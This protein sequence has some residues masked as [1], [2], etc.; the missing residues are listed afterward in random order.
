MWLT[1][2]GNTK[3]GNFDGLYKLPQKMVWDGI[4]KKGNFDGLYKQVMWPTK[5]ENWRGICVYVSR[6]CDL[7]KKEIFDGL[8]KH[9]KNY[10]KRKFD[11][12]HKQI[13]WPTK[14]RKMGIVYINRSYNFPK[15]ENLMDYIS[16]LGRHFLKKLQKGNLMAYV[17]RSHDL[18]KSE[19]GE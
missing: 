6:S 12:L 5:N 16:I 10:Q 17:S 1:I 4:S 11:G 14:K 9:F 7:P 2:Y 3:K 18:P 15:K 8:H 13:M 19:N